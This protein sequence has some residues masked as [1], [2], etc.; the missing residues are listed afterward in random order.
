M[1]L[2]GIVVGA[3][4]GFATLDFSG[5]IAGAFVGWVVALA[6]RSSAQR[7]AASAQ[8]TPASTSAGAPPPPQPLPSPVSGA[9]AVQTPAL[10]GDVDALGA[11]EQRVRAIEARLGIDSPVRDVDVHAAGGPVAP[12]SFRSSDAIDTPERVSADAAATV[13]PGPV[14]STT[15]ASA[16]VASSTVASATMAPGTVARAAV[17]SAAPSTMASSAAGAGTSSPNAL[18]A[19]FT[20]GNVLTRIGVVALF[21]GV[22]LLLKDFAQFLTVPIELRLLAVAIAGATLAGVGA[23]I[24]RTR[25]GYGV[26]L[27]GAGTGIVYL[28]IFAAFRLYDVLP[29]VPAFALLVGLAALTVGLAMRADSQPLAALAIAGGFLAPFLVSTPEASPV[30]LFGYFAVLN[31]AIFVLAWLRAWRALNVLG[32]VFTFALGL[33]WGGRFYRPEHFAS[34]EPFLILFFLFYVTI[35][36]LYARRGPLQH[37]APVDGLLVFGVPLL[38]FALQTALVADSRY[39]AAW[40]AV[41]L[42]VFY[43]VLAAWLWRRAEPGWA[44]LARAFLALAIIFATIAVPF[45]VE[46]RS[47]SGWWALEAAAV[48][49]IGCKQRQGFARGL[50]LI[51]QVGAA[52]AFVMGGIEAG[53]HLFLNATFLGTTMI[54]LAAICTAWLADRHHDAVTARERA[55]MPMV[56]LWGIAWWYGGGVLEVTRALP[57]RSE[58]NGIL[59]FVVGSVS[60]ALLLH[61]LLRWPRLLWFGVGLLPAMAVAGV[62][63]WDAMR[64]TLRAYGWLV[65]PLAWLAQLLVLYAGDQV[66]D[67]AATGR[68]ESGSS[69]QHASA[70]ATL[71]ASAR[72]LHRAHAVSAIAFVVWLAWEASEWVGRAFAEGTVW[73]PCAAALPAIAYLWLATGV[74]NSARWPWRVHGDAYAA[75]AGIVI[76][77][78]LG[79]W[80]VIVNVVSPGD[81]APLPYVPLLNVLDVTLVAALA[82]LFLW[83]RA[84]QGLDE[85]TAYG[86]WGAALFLLVNALVFRAVHQWLDVPWR[87]SALVAS[88]PLQA[89]LTLTWTAV[90]LPLMLVAG[91]R[92]IRPLWMVG[93]AL[94]AVVVVKLF[95]LDLSAL[96]G[97]PRVAAFLGVGVLLLIIGFVAPLPPPVRAPKGG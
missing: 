97:M 16:T 71:D 52:V 9:P 25:P 94:L 22:A 14:A 23:Y 11:L 95:L 37:K 64:T 87:W 66:R 69:T 12:E 45:A 92:A 18:W 28:T 47:T 72:W 21:V 29:A 86:W 68:D 50:A 78:L 80:F 73:M 46:P 77:A 39:G 65:W 26:S 63:D 58:G 60:L 85:R 93:A 36:V 57:S 3:F 17:A 49:W 2:L 84:V 83:A 38:G 67:D 51:L 56:V 54:A 41:G 96:S 82:V 48:Y 90:A 27:E 70:S 6:V 43:G 4:I 55:L 59:A 8:S 75:S 81:T 33:F 79:A 35:A 40:S 34:V 91:R 24:A 13:A 44:L 10:A 76:A 88:K 42:A 32:F 61:R 31:G 20:S 15:V 19:W 74:R 5:A 89:A 1:L 62:L 30:R 7:R 53:G